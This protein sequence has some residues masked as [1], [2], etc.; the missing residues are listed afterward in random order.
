VAEAAVPE[1]SVVIPVFDRAQCIAEAVRSVLAQEGLE[2]EVVVVDD[3]SN[4]G[5]ADVVAEGFADDPRVRVLRQPENRGPSAARNR[6]LAEGLAPLATFLDSDD[7]LVSGGLAT[8]LAALRQ[9]GGPDGVVGS[10][11]L[12]HVE[13]RSPSWATRIYEQGIVEPVWVSVLADRELLASVGF[14]ESMRLAEDLDFYVRLKETGAQVEALEDVVVER[15]RFGDNLTRDLEQGITDLSLVIR[16]ATARRR[17]RAQ[18]DPSG[19]SA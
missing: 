2:L 14:D 15:R 4:D 7:V 3:A 19:G 1:V 11:R 8:Q 10:A 5:S 12:V 9:P 18:V 16:K 17:A 6:G 13:G